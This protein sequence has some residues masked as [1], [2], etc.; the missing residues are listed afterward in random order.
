MKGREG[1][2]REWEGPAPP[3][4]N[5]GSVPVNERVE[6]ATRVGSAQNESLTISR[7][8]LVHSSAL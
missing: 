7:T 4:A 3:F 1:E 2:I 6:N 8:L 5:S